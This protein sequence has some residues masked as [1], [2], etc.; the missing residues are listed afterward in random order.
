[1][2]LRLEVEGRVFE[3]QKPPMKESRFRAVC[4]LAAGGLYVALVWVVATLCGFPGVIAV[5]VVTLLI[6]MTFSMSI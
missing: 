1:M 6:A 2:K 5:A 3:F 4:G